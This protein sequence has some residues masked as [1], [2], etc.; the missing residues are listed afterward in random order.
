MPA[1]L[2]VGYLPGARDGPDDPFTVRASDVHAWVEVWFPTAGW[3]RF[4]PTGRAPDPRAEADSV[5]DRLLRFL[6]KLWPVVVLLVVAGAGWLAWRVAAWRRRRAARPWSTRYF[7][8]LERA[9][10]ARGRPRRPEETPREYA[11]GLARSVLPDPRLEEAGE[12]VT[13]A[14]WSRHEPAGEDKARAEAILKA[15]KK[16]SPVPLLR[17]RRRPR[18]TIARP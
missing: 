2:A 7:T 11:S 6:K 13:V 12:L 15:A 10:R 1:R 14:A 3:Q 16:A 8:R 9:G 4:D 17:R 5:W 18:P